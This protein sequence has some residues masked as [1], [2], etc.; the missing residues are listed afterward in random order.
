MAKKTAKGKKAAK[1]TGAAIA[2]PELKKGEVHAGLI[3]KNGKPSHWVIVLSGEAES[4]TYPDAIDWAKKKG[5]E[6]PT[7]A[8]QSLLFA[9]A[10]EH[11]QPRWYWSGE[12]PA[13]EQ[14]CAWSQTFDGGDQGWDHVNYYYRARAVRRVPVQ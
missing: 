13:G 2:L 10:K 8:E 4:V 11:F 3:L 1:A 7:R 12:Q 6:L 9:N 14:T 5:G